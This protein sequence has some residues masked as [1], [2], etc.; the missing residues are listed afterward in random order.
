MIVSGGGNDT[1]NTGDGDDRVCSEAGVDE[2]NAGNGNDSV[3]A[4]PDADTVRGQGDNDILLGNAGGGDT[5]DVGDT[6]VGGPG[7][8]H[9]DGWVGD[10]VLSV[11]LATTTSGARPVSTWSRTPLRL[12]V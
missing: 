4:G 8:D 9:L 10:D 11:D 2:I 3:F 6:I 7:N 12:P 1:I 5:N